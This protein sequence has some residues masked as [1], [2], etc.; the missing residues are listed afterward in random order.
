MAL[1][2]HRPAAARLEHAVQLQ[3]LLAEVVYRS[4]R[5]ILLMRTALKQP[6]LLA[7]VDNDN[8]KL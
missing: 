2:A 6:L 7:V 4:D 1:L 3:Q 8:G 5:T